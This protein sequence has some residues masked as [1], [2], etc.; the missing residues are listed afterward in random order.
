[1]KR[2]DP[3]KIFVFPVIFSYLDTLLE[4]GKEEAVFG[5]SS[6]Y[7]VLAQDWVEAKNNLRKNPDYW[8]NSEGGF[9]FK[10]GLPG[11]LKQNSGLGK[12]IRK[13]Q[14]PK[15]GARLVIKNTSLEGIDFDLEE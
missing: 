1:M 3:Y 15:F 9:Y 12:E 10:E 6:E 4:E 2:I 11:V 5:R 8:R 13:R 7:V 14:I